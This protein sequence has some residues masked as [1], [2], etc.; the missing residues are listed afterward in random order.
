MAWINCDSERWSRFGL[1]VNGNGTAVRPLLRG[2][3]AYELD[4]SRDSNW[5][6]YTL[7]PE[8]SVWR[9][10]RDGSDQRQ[11][12]PP[13]MVAHQPHWSPDD[14]RIAFMGRQREK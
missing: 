4:Y 13:G 8:H 9:C 3:S 6:A 11:L 2:L 10:R 12:S 14:T 5:I 1:S 7:Y